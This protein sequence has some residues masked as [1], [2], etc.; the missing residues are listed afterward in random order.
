MM[1]KIKQ[2]LREKTIA[3]GLNC[4]SKEESD[5]FD[6]SCTHCQIFHA[7]LKDSEENAIVEILRKITTL[8][9][10]EESSRIVYRLVG[11]YYQSIYPVEEGNYLDLRV[12]FFTEFI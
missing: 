7:F 9:R 6:K 2:E 1:D 8:Y 12:Y 11:I 5:E 10:T 4:L 3:Q